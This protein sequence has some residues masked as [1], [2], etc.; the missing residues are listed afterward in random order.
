MTTPL[1]S[2]SWNMREKA[3]SSLIHRF[4]DNEQGGVLMD[5]SRIR[6]LGI[7]IWFFWF[8]LFT[9]VPIF[10]TYIKDL[11]ISYG[12]IG[13]I[14][15]SYG[16]TQLLLRIPLG[17][18]SDKIQKRKIFITS[19]MFL[20]VI[21]SLGM[22]FFQDAVAL[23]I[24]RAIS[25]IAVATWVI[26]T[27]LFAS[28]F[29][30]FETSKAMGLVNSILNLAQVIAMLVGGIIAYRYGPE[31]TFLLSAGA[32][33]VG[34]F[35]S[36]RISENLVIE[37]T[38]MNLV[39]LLETAKDRML[40]LTSLL[41]FIYQLV[42]YGT[43]FG[44]VPIVAKN[45]GANNFE[46]GLLPTLFMLPSILSSSLSGTL[47]IR[48]IIGERHMIGIGFLVIILSCSSIPLISNL[49]YLYISQILCGFARGLVFPLL[50]SF[51]I[52]HITDNKRAT[53]MGYFQAVYAAG[54][55]LG[56]VIIGILSSLIGLAWGFWSVCIFAGTGVIV[57]LYFLNE[58]HSEV[59]RSNV[60]ADDKMIH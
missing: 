16:F 38:P 53:A 52:K 3:I 33:T 23:L 20:C 40:N 48:Y 22:W 11:G 10:P 55:F 34:L 45:L 37:R 46:L 5:K 25:G 56:P 51:S 29:H 28:Y 47:F 32:G 18:L 57:V 26:Q 6:L 24:L 30:S 44:F 4:V 50:M 12:M 43:I 14:L 60:A 7:I 19:G 39:N 54:I 21:S 59:S 27:V 17:V 1:L 58:N 8:S 15:G 31:L 2:I 42:T 49:K 9:Y 13:I 41:G 36:F 35:L